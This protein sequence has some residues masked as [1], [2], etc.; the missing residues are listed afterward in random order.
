M[1]K[2][3]VSGLSRKGAEPGV[4]LLGN[5]LNRISRGPSWEDLL[6]KLADAAELPKKGYQLDP[7]KPFPLL[8]E[9]LVLKSEVDRGKIE[10]IFRAEVLEFSG[11]LEW[12]SLHEA[13]LK[14]GFHHY[15]TTNYDFTLERAGTEEPLVF[16][17]AGMK[18]EI[19]YSIFRRYHLREKH[20]WHIHG[21]IDHPASIMLGCDHYAGALERI[22]RYTTSRVGYGRDRKEVARRLRHGLKTMD[23]WLDF[24]FITDFTSSA[25]LWIWSRCTSGGSSPVG[26]ACWPRTR[27][28]RGGSTSTFTASQASADPVTKSASWSSSTLSVSMWWRSKCEAG[29][30][31]SS[32][33]RP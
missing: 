17:N 26:H 5:G 30:G 4:I 33:K 8:Y 29:G 22:R 28:S 1:A 20:F 6:L 27:R 15:L 9:E 13:A 10:E 19:R 21:D 2:A 23:S 7:E 16:R 12:H 31:R 24:F 14:L 32:T 18:P 25:W 11:E 3:P